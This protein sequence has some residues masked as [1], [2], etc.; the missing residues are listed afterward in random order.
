VASCEGR[1]NEGRGKEEGEEIKNT[2]D[3]P[4]YHE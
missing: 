1:G 4:K 2:L 3:I